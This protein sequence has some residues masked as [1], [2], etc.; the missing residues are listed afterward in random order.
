MLKNKRYLDV[1]GVVPIRLS[2][3]GGGGGGFGGGGAEGLLLGILSGGVPL[4]STN[5]NPIS[6]Q[7]MSYSHPFSDLASNA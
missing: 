4:G 3:R 7:K 1:K 2:P 6:D 5:S